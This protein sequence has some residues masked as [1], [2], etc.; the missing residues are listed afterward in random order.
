MLQKVGFEPGPF[1]TL[2]PPH[3]WLLLYVCTDAS[4]VGFFLVLVVQLHF[5]LCRQVTLD[6]YHGTRPV[7]ATLESPWKAKTESFYE[8][9]VFDAWQDI[10]FCVTSFMHFFILLEDNQSQTRRRHGLKLVS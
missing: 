3:I 8:R 4:L 5:S 1:G 10:F 7:T 9:V 2:F 6:I